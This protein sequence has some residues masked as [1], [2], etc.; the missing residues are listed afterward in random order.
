[1][2]YLADAREYLLVEVGAERLAEPVESAVSVKNQPET[3]RS[4]RSALTRWWW[5]SCPRPAAW[6]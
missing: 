2:Q 4:S 5:C 3:R 1:M 6:A